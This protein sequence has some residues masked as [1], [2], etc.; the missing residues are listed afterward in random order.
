[1]WVW[2]ESGWEIGWM[3]VCGRGVDVGVGGEWMRDWVD[4]SVWVESGWEIVWMR[5]CGWRVD[6][7]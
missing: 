2:V 1:M 5:V 7:R 4:E 6:E 3:R